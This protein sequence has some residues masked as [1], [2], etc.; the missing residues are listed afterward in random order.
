MVSQHISTLQVLRQA[1]DKASDIYFIESGLVSLVSGSEDEMVET[2]LVGPEGMVGCC[3]LLGETTVSSSAIARS[4]GSAW[5]I[6]RHD[7]LRAVDA[8]RALHRLLLSYIHMRMLGAARAIIAASR[9]TIEQRVAGWLLMAQDRLG[10]E[11]LPH[12]HDHLAA[13]LGVR[14]PG[15]TVAMHILEGEHAIISR[16]GRILI[17]SREILQ[18]RAGSAYGAPPFIEAADRAKPMGARRS[19]PADQHWRGAREA[20][21]LTAGA[22]G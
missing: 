22:T 6:A 12:T 9:C 4:A 5:R 13:A 1:G 19:R 8:D 3:A 14:R 15:V 7:L 2:T 20:E 21:S 11:E 10:I 18:Q 16:R 17:R